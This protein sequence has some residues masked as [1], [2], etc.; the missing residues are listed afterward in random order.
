VPVT[1]VFQALSLVEK[2]ELVEV[3][4]A[5]HLRDIRSECTARWNESLYV[6]SIG[7]CFMVA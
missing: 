4:F 2:A 7:S 6:A 5:L 3:R 1:F